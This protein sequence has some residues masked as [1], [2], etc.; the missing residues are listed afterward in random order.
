MDPWPGMH[1]GRH[2]YSED[3]LHW[4]GGD[5]DCWNNTVAVEGGGTITLARRERPELVHNE[6]GRPVALISG[7][8][9]QHGAA[10]PGNPGDQ[11][12]TMCVGVNHQK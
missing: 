3:G 7:V 6:E 12:T 11:T 9:Y 2:A 8:Q 4:H 10:W 5:I 1:T